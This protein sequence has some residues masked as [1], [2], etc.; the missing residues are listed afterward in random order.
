MSE[1]NK[2]RL[3]KT[4]L[5]VSELGMGCFRMTGEFGVDRQEGS[6]ILDLAFDAGIN[7][8]DTAQMYGWGEGE[9]M[10]GRAFRRHSDKE[11][12]VSDKVGWLDRTIVRNLEGD[13][14]VDDKAL[15]RV[16]E[17]SFWLMQRDYIDIFMIHEYNAPTWKIDYSTGDSVVMD[18]LESLKAQGRI[19]AIG[20]GTWGTSD[21]LCRDI[22]T[23]MD[24]GR[25]DVALLAGG[26]NVM[27]QP[28]RA[29]V[30]PAAERNDVGIVVGAAFGAGLP[31]LINKDRQA[32]QRRI[33]DADYDAGSYTENRCTALLKLFDISD[34]TGLPTTEMCIRYLL[35]EQRIHS[36]IAGAC[37]VAHL[38]SNIESA[39]K[40]PLPTDIEDAI[41][42]I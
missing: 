39:L 31:E 18:V 2:R 8:F 41:T 38:Q 26:Y 20:I 28:I 24:S 36:H 17:H 40:G 16:I 29:D 10:L 22:V 27:E 7:Y 3:G 35:G 4:D 34:E 5:M 13:A 11:A 32:I 37:E 1:I 9:E 6:A 42:N 25:I 33:D 15:R 12:F 30:L 21:D 19:G 14:Y 23:L